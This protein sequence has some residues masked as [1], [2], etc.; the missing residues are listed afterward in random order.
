VS[1]DASSVAVLAS[2]GVARFQSLLLELAPDILLANQDEAQL[3]A[4]DSRAPDG[5]GLLVAHAG[6]GPAVAADAHGPRAAVRPAVAHDAQDTTGAGDAF[7]AGFLPA[8]RRR[9]P[10]QAALAAGHR[11]AARTLDAPGAS[12]GAVTR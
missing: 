5:V 7:A 2:Y 8:L 11:C 12:I 1:I 9:D 3:L 6:A 4:P 10:L